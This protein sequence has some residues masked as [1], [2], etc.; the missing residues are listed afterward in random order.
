LN[1]GS[2]GPEKA[3]F[4]SPKSK[5]YMKATYYGHACFMIEVAGK[6]L[7]FDP[8][9]TDN[10][11][12]RDIDISKIK[13]DYILISHGHSDHVADVERIATASG[14]MIVSN[15][16]VVQWFAAKGLNNNHPMNIGGSWTFDF[17]TLTYTSALHSSS[18][19]DGSYG[20]NPGGFLVCSEEGNFY[21]AGD[22]GLFSDM[23]LITTEIKL[24]FAIL[25]IGDNFTM[26]INDA[27][28]ATD[29]L[30][31]SKV[32]G[33]HYDT[34]P[35]IEIDSEEAIS[36]FTGTGKELILIEIGKSIKL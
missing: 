5:S 11:L 1:L 17:G 31:C 30:G 26:G 13:P 19:P 10:P 29:F 9:I 7:L 2:P 12:A 8:F 23:R 3:Y 15:F 24:D 32:I 33:M 34:F 14:A 6:K 25:P 18:M 36:S 35:Y 22:T 16:E 21:Y 28:H 4:C 20:G 27:I